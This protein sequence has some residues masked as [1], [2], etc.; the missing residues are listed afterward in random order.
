[1]GPSPARESYLVPE[2]LLSAAKRTGATLLHPGFGFLS[3]NAAFARAVLDAGIAWVGPSPSSI[4]AM[5]SKTESRRRMQAAGVP[6]VPGMTT[7]AKDA[8]EVVAF[9]EAHG[10]PLLLKAAAG[11][12][13]KGMRVVRAPEEVPSVFARA[14]SEAKS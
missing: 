6:I 7:A 3:E 10:F 2:K 14:S 9:G 5:G 8:E 12:G 13:G 11:G 1:I 4:E